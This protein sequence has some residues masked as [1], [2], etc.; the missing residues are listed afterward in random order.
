M[1]HFPNRRSQLN[2]CGQMDSCEGVIIRDTD[3]ISLEWWI[4]FSQNKFKKFHLLCHTF[5]FKDKM[6]NKRVC[7]VCLSLFRSM[8]RTS[9]RPPTIRRW[10]RSAPPRS[11][12]WSRFCAGPLTPNWSAPPLTPKSQTS[13]PRL[14]SHS[15]TSWPL[16]SCLPPHPQW[17]SWTSI[18]CQRSKHQIGLLGTKDKIP[19]WSSSVSNCIWSALNN[20]KHWYQ[21][22][23]TQRKKK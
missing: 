16:P 20:I 2:L 5:L 10:R 8:A 12:S 19:I 1:S 15:S 4:S 21:C 3:Y 22:L 6:L 14:T 17:R 7:F 23:I 18:C 9:L 11:P 13:A